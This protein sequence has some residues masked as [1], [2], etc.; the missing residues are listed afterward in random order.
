METK[1]SDE[2]NVTQAY[3]KGWDVMSG[4][5][6]ILLLIILISSLLAALSGNY[7][8]GEKESLGILRSLFW[9]FISIPVSFGTHWVFLKAARKEP[10]QI[11]DMFS[12]FSTKYWNVV[13][14]GFL[15]TIISIVGFIMLI[16]PGIIVVVRLVFVPYLVM[17]RQMKALE[18]IDESWKMTKG[19]FWT[20]FF[21]GLLSIFIGLAG[22]LMLIIGIFPALI[23]IYGTFAS[24]YDM[25]DNK[26]PKII[27]I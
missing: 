2:I 14:A 17:D 22:I 7:Y 1:K 6:G 10:F 3:S 9:L 21:T 16:I 5:F 18:A 27:S 4:N 15:V 8:H 20:I 25:I 26:T 13:L 23:W 11:Q 24:L 12:A 19:Y